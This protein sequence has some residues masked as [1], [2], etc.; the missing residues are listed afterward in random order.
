MGQS[1]V[2]LML[3]T[4]I[5]EKNLDIMWKHAEIPFLCF[6]ENDG[7]GAIVLKKETE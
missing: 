2:E 1:G 3:F 5:I 7:V 4:E 6:I